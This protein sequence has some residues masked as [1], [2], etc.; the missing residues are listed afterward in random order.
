MPKTTSFYHNIHDPSDEA[1]V[2]IDGRMVDM[3][4]NRMQPWKTKR[5]IASAR[6]RCGRKTL[7]EEYEDVLRTAARFCTRRGL[8]MNGVEFQAIAWSV[9]KQ[10]ETQGLTARG[11]PRKQGPPRHGQP[12]AGRR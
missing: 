11:N 8:P 4:V 7:Y 12:Y 9:G 2:T 10:I 6:L 1:W 3:I 5:G